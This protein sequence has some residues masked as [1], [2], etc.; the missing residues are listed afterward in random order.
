MCCYLRFRTTPADLKEFLTSLDK[1][2]ED[3]TADEEVL[4]QDDSDSVELPWKIGT[5]G[6]LAGLYADIPEQGDNVGTALLTV[7]ESELAAP[8]VCVHV[9]V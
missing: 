3:L 2:A 8:L 5:K 1:T 4:D 9:T 7:D 6:H